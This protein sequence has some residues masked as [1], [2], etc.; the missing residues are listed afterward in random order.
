MTADQPVIG[1][2]DPPRIIALI[3]TI[4]RRMERD[5]TMSTLLAASGAA[6]HALALLAADRRA[7]GRDA[8]DPIEATI[9]HLRAAASTR[10][11]VGELAGMAGLSE[12]HY[13]ALFRQATGYGVL[14]CRTR[15][16]MGLARELLDMTH[17][18]IS[19]I[20]QQVGYPDP[21]YFSRQFRRI[22]AMSPS[23]YRSRDAG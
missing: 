4:I 18:T 15:Q 16:R 21:L 13:A 10:V 22:H 11:S 19:S 12:S 7:V 1:L 9:E 14:E 23:E 20:A 3:D 17:R 6:W 2:G 5:E 8:V